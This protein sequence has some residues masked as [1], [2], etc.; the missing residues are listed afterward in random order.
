[1]RR[2]RE[3]RQGHFPWLALLALVGCGP[4]RPPPSPPATP[5]PLR[6]TVTT[7]RV[8]GTEERDAGLDCVH[9]KVSCELGTC[10]AEL[11]NDCEREIRCELRAEAT[12]LDLPRTAAT[13]KDQ[14][15]KEPT[16]AQATVVLPEATATTLEATADCGGSPVT[17]TR[18][19]HLACT[20]MSDALSAPAPR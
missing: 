17:D 13:N 5:P 3:N 7:T 19:P 14:G 9:A 10:T 18:A 4:V 1:M 16:A 2:L 12:C 8:D 11:H 6:R 15:P 20:A